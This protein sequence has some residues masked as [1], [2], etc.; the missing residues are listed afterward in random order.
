VDISEFGGFIPKNDYSCSMPNASV[1]IEI[2]ATDPYSHFDLGFMGNYTLYN[3]NETLNLTIAAPFSSHVFGNDSTCMIKI[4]ESIIPYEV[5]E[6]QRGDTYSWDDYIS[7]YHRNLIVCNITLPLNKSIILEYKFKTHINS[8][9]NDV[10]YM[11]FHYDIGTASV[12]NG[13][14]SERIEFKVH[15][16]LP[17]KYLNTTFLRIID[18]PDGKSY[19]WEW[20]DVSF[21]TGYLSVY[22]SYD[23]NYVYN[24]GRII[25]FGNFYLLFLLLGFISLVILQRRAVSLN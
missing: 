11:E 2:N 13:T 17:D 24:W 10:G 15:G 9:L 23:G 21:P 22:I 1:V 3:P 5:I 20:R 6:Y 25:S 14:I 19:I 7:I 18:I 12:W 8:P 16:R 4:N